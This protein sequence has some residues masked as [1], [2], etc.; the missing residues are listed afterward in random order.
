MKRLLFSIGIVLLFSATAFAVELASEDFESGIFPPTGWTVET[1]NTNYSI[2]YGPEYA[3][4]WHESPYWFSYSEP[5]SARVFASVYDYFGLQDELLVTPAIDLS[6]YTSAGVTFWNLSIIF[7]ETTVTLEASTDYNKKG[8]KATWTTLYT[9]PLTTNISWELVDID[10]AP[11]VG[12]TVWL[13]WHYVYTGANEILGFGS[14]Y[15]LD[16]ITISAGTADDDD[17]DDDNDDNDNDDNDDDNDD[18]DNNDDNDNDDLPSDDDDE[19]P[20]SNF[21]DDDDEEGGC[22]SS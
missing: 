4:T 5:T 19:A 21:G 12:Q 7:D 9:Y 3:Y 8:N 13:A 11:Y 16:D 20:P 22:C 15:Y 17:D 6:S 10:L 2:F 18:D 1:T 14:D